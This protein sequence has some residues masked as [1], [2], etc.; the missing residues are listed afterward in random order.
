[1]ISEG[2]LFH[3]NI[4]TMGKCSARHIKCATAA[5]NS[6]AIIAIKILGGKE[7]YRTIVSGD[8]IRVNPAR[9]AG[10]KPDE[11]SIVDV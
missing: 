2:C 4:E 3:V 9:N 5:R 11:V 1:M 6:R 7:L 10:N 8:A